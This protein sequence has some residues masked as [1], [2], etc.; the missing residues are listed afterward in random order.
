MAPDGAREVGQEEP[1]LT[2]DPNQGL[3]RS[4]RTLFA[5]S[6]LSNCQLMNVIRNTRVCN[7]QYWIYLF[8]RHD[9]LGP[10]G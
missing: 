8:A 4:Q 3:A 7:E 9:R 1:N 2:V 5:R 6:T 10:Q